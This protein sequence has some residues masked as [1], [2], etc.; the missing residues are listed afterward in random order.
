MS[1]IIREHGL[2]SISNQ[3]NT[4]ATTVERQEASGSRFT[5]VNN[6]SVLEAAEMESDS[7][8]LI[9]TSIPFCYDQETEILTK[10]G[11][12]GFGELKQYD[13]VA[14]VNPDRLCFEWQIPKKIVWENYQGEMLKFGNRCFDL[15]VTPNHRIFAARRGKGFCPEKLHLVEAQE[16]AK[17]YE[18]SKRRKH[19]SGRISRSWKTCLV[20]PNDGHGDWP[21]KILIPSLPEGVRSGHGVQLYWVE[22]R[23]FMMLAGWFLSEGF[24]DSFEAGR[25][26]GRISIAQV[27]KEKY[28]K[29]IQDMFLRIGLPPSIH[30]RQITVWCRNLAYFLIHQFGTG[31]KN[32]RIPEWVRNLHPGL[33]RILRDTMMKGDGT[34][35]KCYTSFSRELRDN[36]QEICLKT[37]WRAT[38]KKNTALV[39]SKQVYPEIRKA[40]SRVNYNGMIGCVTVANGIVI[41][42][43]NGKPCVCGNS[44][45]YEYTP[46]FFDFGHTESNDHFWN[47]MDFLSPNLHRVLSPGRI[48][49][50]HVKDRIVPGGI[51]KLGFQTLHPFHAEAI[52]HYQKHGF[53]FLGMKTIV[54][55]V[56]RENNQT[57]RLGWTEQCKDG[58][59]MGCGVPEYLLLFRKPP[60]DRSNGYADVP[61][62]KNKPDTEYPDGRTGPYD[63]E[64]GKIIPGTGYSRSR[65]QL[66]ACGFTRVSGNRLL[67]KDDME[68]LPHEKIYK[69][70]KQ[71]NLNTIYDFEEHNRLG[72]EMEREKRLP[73][74]FAI[75]PPHSWHPDVWTDI[76]RMRTMNMEQERRGQELHLCPMQFDIVER[77]INQMTNPDDLV[78]DPFAG[79]GTVPYVA[80]KMGRRGFGC[81]LSPTYWKDSVRYCRLAEQEAKVGSL[82][83]LLD[84]A[85]E[86]E[87]DDLV[88][89]I[90][91]NE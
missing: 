78:F 27:T 48:L 40:P 66:D 75:M 68:K 53:A 7:A 55:D 16:I 70:W 11:W 84:A 37:G 24:A 74:T 67:T 35:T 36:F 63:Y 83:D 91:S 71:W 90:Y 81:E 14:T 25:Q 1:R 46:S 33:L 59:R 39:G 30:P 41:V 12:I 82:F 21:E 65:W 28:R 87:K 47:Q 64:G 79:L 60:T 8:G 42:R 38:I 73:A 15:L 89:P 2:A 45:Q 18:L 9:L 54:T 10:R 31:S 77:V 44:F 26:G 32:K 23:D 52:Y 6:D 72:E 43:R 57:Y 85:D 80:I 58:S 61:V 88:T 5:L 69:L 76:A 62:V 56:V 20:P 29:E 86:P 13:E 51:N 49:A 22:A 17:D 19:A 3:Q 4:R 50:I 34:G